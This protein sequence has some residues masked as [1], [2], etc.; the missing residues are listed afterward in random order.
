MEVFLWCGVLL[1]VCLACIPVL[2]WLRRRL[3]A[4]AGGGESVDFSA[5]QIRKL[6]KKGQ[7]TDEEYKQLRRTALGLKDLEQEN[8]PSELTKP[9]GCDDG[10]SDETSA[11]TV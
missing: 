7:L 3:R 8:P 1:A 10:N 11:G 9:A 2:V 5:E 6:W 4:K